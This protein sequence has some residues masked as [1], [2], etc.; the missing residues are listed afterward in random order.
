MQRLE[1]ST[2]GSASIVSKAP[3]KRGSEATS[4]SISAS[5]SSFTH[6]VQL[7]SQHKEDE[8]LAHIKEHVSSIKDAIS[9]LEILDGAEYAEE[10]GNLRKE[11]ALAV[12][13]Q[14]RMMKKRTE[15]Y[16]QIRASES[17][18][19]VFA[20]QLVSSAS[21]SLFPR[22]TP[23]SAFTS[24][25]ADATQYP[26]VNYNDE[27]EPEHWIQYE[28]PA[29][30]DKLLYASFGQVTPGCDSSWSRVQPTLIDF[31][32]LVAIHNYLKDVT[33]L[34]DRIA[35]EKWIRLV[36]ERLN[37]PVGPY[38]VEDDERAPKRQR[39]SEDQVRASTHHMC[40][41]TCL[42]SMPCLIPNEI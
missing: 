33:M 26:P 16:K 38:L 30:L 8:E 14:V 24:P 42:I 27:S 10:L 3:K 20:D 22:S 13:H 39:G 19:D 32:R 2:T 6:T 21:M 37:V 17:A 5:T 34:E 1:R 40:I 23:L 35:L 31:T 9:T 18:G 29:Q 41:T 4:S 7:V 12:I 36:G 25:D 15:Q 28:N 11:L